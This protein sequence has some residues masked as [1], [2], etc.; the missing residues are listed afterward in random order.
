MSAYSTI[1]NFS[2]TINTA[3]PVP[4]VDNDTQGFRDNY[5]KIVNSFAVASGEITGLLQANN[6]LQTIITNATVV[7]S[8]YAT[9]IA[10]SVTTL[11]INSLTIGAPD[12]VTP[13]VNLWYT[14]T[15][16][17]A[18]LTLSNII[19]TSTAY[20]QGQINADETNI[21]AL[22]TTTA[23]LAN[24]STIIYNSLTN[25]VVP[26]IDGHSSQFVTV[27]TEI[28]QLQTTASNLWVASQ[29]LINGTFQSQLSNVITTASNLFN[30]TYGN[31]G[32]LNNLSTINSE[33]SALQAAQAN[34]L[35]NVSVPTS[36]KGKTG[37]KT[38]MIAVT[39]QYLFYCYGNYNGSSDIWAYVAVA[40]T[41]TT[42]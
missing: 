9:N 1:T 32:I 31:T 37:D 29:P 23:V 26:V 3:F 12:I 28:S 7:G 34:S 20:L 35:N 13:T 27:N 30:I 24:T 39:D 19:S 10:N 18:L 38:G 8:N 25:Y 14:T 2:N 5:S 42:W 17:S 41:S 21:A 4:G 36:S 33:I 22:Q 15:I 6:N 40:N 16:T 11:V